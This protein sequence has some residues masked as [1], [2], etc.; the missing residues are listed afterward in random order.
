[1]TK[2]IKKENLSPEFK[3]VI[4]GM[5]KEVADQLYNIIGAFAES[6]KLLAIGGF[7]MVDMEDEEDDKD[8]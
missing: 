6:H 5:P 8:K 4:E 2:E 7:V 1:M 3:F